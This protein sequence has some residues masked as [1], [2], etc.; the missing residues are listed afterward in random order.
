MKN[1]WKQISMTNQEIKSMTARDFR[2]LMF[3]LS[4]NRKIEM[5]KK[6]CSIRLGKSNISDQQ[7]LDLKL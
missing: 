2:K 1:Y 7:I 3:E 6:I 5:L 4:T